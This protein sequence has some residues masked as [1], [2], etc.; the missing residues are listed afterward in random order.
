MATR[1]E[2][3]RLTLEDAGFTTGMAKAAAATALLERS[4]DS[5]DGT[6]VKTGSSTKGLSEETDGLGKS[7]QKTTKT[8]K[9]YTLEL[10]LVEERAAR[11]KKAIRDQARAQLDAADAVNQT[12]LE[13]EKEADSFRKTDRSINQLTGRL[14]L[15]ADAAA[16]LGPALVPLGA[17]A[18]PALAGMV[19]QLGVLVA[20]GGTAILTFAGMGD[21]IESMNEYQLEPTADNLQ[22]MR[23]EMEKLGPAGADFVRFLDTIEPQLKSLQLVAREGMLPGVEDGI[24]SLLERLPQVRS[25]IGDLASTMGDLAR[26]A[27]AGLAGSEFNAFFQYLDAEAG[28]ILSDFGRTIGNFTLGLSNMIVGLGP[29]TADFSGGLLEMSRSF[30]DWSAG[31][32]SNQGWQ[33][34]VSYVQQSGPQILD[35]FGSLANL[36]VQV[37]QAAAPVGLVVV[38]ALTAMVDVLAALAD[39]PLGTVFLSAAAAMAVYSR[40]AEL[41]GRANAR[42]ATTTTAASASLARMKG[43]AAGLQ[44]HWK[45]AAAGAGI[46]ALSM[47]D[48]DDK[49]GMANTAMFGLAG[50]MVGGAWGAAIGTTIGATM[51]LASANDDLATAMENA[52]DAARSGSFELQTQRLRELKDESRDSKDA[53]EDFKD[54]FRVRDS[55]GEGYV[56][57]LKDAWKGLG[58]VIAGESG[59][60]AGAQRELNDAMRQGGGIADIFARDIGQTGAAFSMA[61]GGAREFSGALAELNGWFDK[62]EALRNYRASLDDLREGLKSSF[63]PETAGQID[64]VGRNLLTVASQIKD[65]GLREDFLQGARASLNDLAQNAGP[66][67][68]A[69]VQRVIEKLDEYGLTKPPSPK[70]GADTT[71]AERDLD[72]LQRQ[73]RKYGLTRETGT[74]ALRDIATGKIK[75]VQGLI[76]KYGLT[77]AEARALL[78]DE[79]SGKINALQGQLAG[80]PRTITTTHKL[81]RL[82]SG[83]P[84]GTGGGRS[85]PTLGGLV[86]QADGGSVPKTGLPYA[87]RHPYLLADGEEVISNRYGQADR[88]RSL[89]KA[90]NANRAADGATV[91]RSTMGWQGTSDLHWITG[92][93]SDLAWESKNLTNS[94]G[95]LTKGSIR[96]MKQR[97]RALQRD[98]KAAEEVLQARKDEVKA[99]RD[100]RQAMKEQVAGNFMSDVFGDIDVESAARD[101]LLGSSVMQKV[102]AW[103]Q[104]QNQAAL[105]R[106]EDA[107][108]QGGSPTDWVGEYLKT[109]SS[110]ERDEITNSV[111]GNILNRD[112][113]RSGDFETAL[114]KLQ[115]KGL[116][117]AA[118]QNLAES[119]NLS[120]AS[121]Y[122]G[123]T[124]K[125]IDQ[126]ERQYNTRDLSAT[127]VGQYAAGAQFD[128]SIKVAEQMRDEARE[129]KQ[130]AA[131]ASQRQERLLSQMEKRLDRIEKNAPK[132]TGRAVAGAIN[133]AVT[134]GTRRA[135]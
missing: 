13:V 11:A 64:A 54:L 16:V 5:L 78:R 10:A 42:I 72:A 120:A 122:A 119:G 95:V 58:L 131:Q 86:P 19:T 80:I 88:H 31:L 109:L 113:I 96:E 30:A 52:Q 28:P 8:T 4:L 101:G 118:F 66:K 76:N 51:D 21:A 74:A 20:A 116:N 6:N 47:T 124:R 121:Y 37:A 130:S 111:R 105:A 14:R 134:H 48:L 79:A 77:K 2:A 133:G 93:L 85:D 50:L 125:E 45:G 38:P 94:L 62:R 107:P 24:S 27:G 128:R 132:E 100:S 89:L 46:L 123:M 9:E 84:A 87:D 53:I 59:K 7:Q 32:E 83:S 60:T 112:T 67:G 82:Y 98:L 40:S 75:S 61:A 108:L 115:K 39:S 99:L 103:G 126:F 34:F 104:S 12:S 35:L 17:A 117:G 36:F 63:T 92:P 43:A 57:N 114:E 69:A 68:A 49:A 55:D 18:V 127:G 23:L 29:V 3:V 97:D 110:S 70:L 81:I 91:G 71:G 44:T 1:N 25:I 129:A 90:I 22:A 73:F 41:I 106:G 135:S 33:N 102:S 56:S 65:K 26:D 15:F